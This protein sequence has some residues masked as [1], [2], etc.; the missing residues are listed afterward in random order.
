M[1]LAPES[2][3]D[4]SQGEQGWEPWRAGGQAQRGGE[5]GRRACLLGGLNAEALCPPARRCVHTFPPLS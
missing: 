3:P 4:A 2:V 5:G 1:S